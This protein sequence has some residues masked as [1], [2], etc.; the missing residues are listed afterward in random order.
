MGAA[1]ST[2]VRERPRLHR[3]GGPSSFP[4]LARTQT[5]RRPV[6]KAAYG[7]AT[8]TVIRDGDGSRSGTHTWSPP[9]PVQGSKASV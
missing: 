4:F 7:C 5:F 6:A 3:R 1:R 2:P 8:V 9:V